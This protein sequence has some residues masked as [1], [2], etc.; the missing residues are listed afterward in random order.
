MM[1]QGIKRRTLMTAELCIAAAFALLAIFTMHIKGAMVSPSGLATVSGLGEVLEISS[2]DGSDCV[3][4]LKADM[5]GD[6]LIYN[7]GEDTTHP[8]T[9]Y[10]NSFSTIRLKGHVTLIQTGSQT[11]SEIVTEGGKVEIDGYHAGKVLNGTG[12]EVTISNTGTLALPVSAFNLENYGDFYNFGKIDCSQD[13]KVMNAGTF[14]NET[15]ASFETASGVTIDNQ[16]EFINNGTM[17]AWYDGFNIAGWMTDPAAAV[18]N[19]GKIDAPSLTVGQGVGTYADSSTTYYEVYDE[20]IKK[21]T[22][23]LYGVV[24]INQ[25]TEVT[26]PGGQMCIMVEAFGTKIYTGVYNKVKGSSFIPTY[27]D[28]AVTLDALP[29]VYY[30]QAYDFT[31]K[32]HT[33][34]DYPET[35]YLLY[36]T[37]AD[38]TYTKQQPANIGTYYAKAFAPGNED[39]DEGESSP[40]S[41]KIEYAPLSAFDRADDFNYLSLEGTNGFY[42]KDSITLTPHSG[43]KVKIGSTSDFAE[44]LTLRESD[45]YSG[46]TFNSGLKFYLKR[47]DGAE[48]SIFSYS[49]LL[50]DLDKVIFDPDPPVIPDEVAADGVTVSIPSD[51]I[52]RAEKII[53][54]ITDRSLDKVEVS[55]SDTQTLTRTSGDVKADG[56]VY[57][58]EV[59]LQATFGEAKSFT[60]KAVDMAG[61][62]STLDLTLKYPLITPTATVS[63]PDSVCGSEYAP[64]V[65]TPSDGKQSFS[66]KKSTDPDTDYSATKPTVAGTYTVLAVIAETDV[67]KETSC[68]ATFTITRK[69][70]SATLTVADTLVGREI[71]PVINTESDGKDDAVFY[72]KKSSESDSAYSTVIPEEAGTYT[73]LAKIPETG[74]YEAASATATFK[75]QKYS[76]GQSKVEVADSYVGMSYEPVITSD[77]DGIDLAVFEYKKSDAP[78]TDY[79]SEKPSKVG[80]YTVRA[81]IPETMKYEKLV[82]TAT[83]K[84][85]K[86][87]ATT[88]VSIPDL[89]VGTSYEP[90]LSTDSDGKENATFVYKDNSAEG[91]TFV[92][93]KPS[94]VGSYTVKVVIPATE[95][96]EASGA[97]A[98]FSIKRKVAT[99]SLTQK[100]VYA[101]TDYEPSLSTASDGAKNVSYTYKQ[102]DTEGAVFTVV[103]P[104]L[105]GNYVVR[106]TIPATDT[107]DA[108]TCEAKYTISYLKK[109][110]PAYE[111]SGTRGD[112]NYYTSN[113]YIKAPEGFLISQDDVSG[114]WESKL[115][116]DKDLT[117]VYLKRKEDGALTAAVKI[118][119]TI[120]IDK[121]E[122]FIKQATTDEG[123]E[124]EIK[125]GQTIYADSLKLVL[126][127]NHLDEVLIG[128]RSIKISGKTATE[129][130]EPAGGEQ[131]FTVK[132]KDKAGNEFETKFT[133]ISSWEQKGVVPKGKKI[134][135]KKGKA[136]KLE[137]GTWKISGDSTVYNG[138]CSVYVRSDG[139]YTFT[140]Q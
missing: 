102:Q 33:E 5:A 78:D 77:S 75:I 51:G 116:W 104:I 82:L 66:Y 132:A 136:Y 124:L 115:K 58:A 128:G 41:F 68:T 48:S 100:D 25:T 94:K 114:T 92:S 47:D 13:S 122:P 14:T 22:T 1:K 139:E 134:K 17:K 85:M 53:L 117:K 2:T 54:T 23:D 140:Q 130:L 61:N 21:D 73:V 120:L 62:S 4:V 88:S 43:Y 71:L 110:D 106:A 89:T 81:T 24:H 80:S 15:G 126:Y 105:P 38:G 131:T 49:E 118:R 28:P 111:I 42:A 129:T 86:K 56:D 32:I 99:G 107:Y 90:S 64:L 30:G 101:G 46:G 55:G 19:N 60:I 16:G 26:S 123:R 59:V 63:V 44:S 83:F 45:L 121:K 72:Y 69:S 133:L 6:Q 8:E 74:M 10:P 34:A 119:E 96:Y 135:L 87:K 137:A 93:E 108:V 11:S 138:G 37:T 125:K 20:F 40:E 3:V 112:N 98:V 109:P 65:T 97:E 76:V 91:N 113:V 7:D 57:K 79:T 39:Y 50:A 31:S 27:L 52:L 84:I 18:Y 35:P 9:T 67:Y 95:T 103:R 127:D 29:T 36:S 70:V 12:C